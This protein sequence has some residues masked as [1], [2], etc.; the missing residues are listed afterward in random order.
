MALVTPRYVQITLTLLCRRDDG[1]C[2]SECSAPNFRLY[3]NL[4]VVL[5]GHELKKQE[6]KIRLYEMDIL[7][8]SIM[9]VV[10]V[11]C[12][13]VICAFE[14]PWSC[15]KKVSPTDDVES[16]MNND[17]D[18]DYVSP[19]PDYANLPP[20]IYCALPPKYDDTCSKPYEVTV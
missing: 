13:F 10:F 11:I 3:N 17:E 2:W 16:G 14:I 1:G 7:T 5:F 19:P 18:A 15:G 9:G 6:Q 8:L 12:V 4:K 20:P